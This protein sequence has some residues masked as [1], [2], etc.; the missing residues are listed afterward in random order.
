MPEHGRNKT[1]AIRD[2][3]IAKEMSGELRANRYTRAEEERELQPPGEDQPE[4]DRAPGT[5]LVG[6]TPPGITAEGVEVRSELGR[7]LG[8]AVYPADRE[9]VLETL[10]SN[11]APDRLMELAGRL[12]DG[13]YGNLQAI[14]DALGLGGEDRRT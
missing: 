5:T 14:A 11:H 13:E 6:G 3:V 8:R 12:P 2:D 4:M 10:R 1:S 7:N 9:A